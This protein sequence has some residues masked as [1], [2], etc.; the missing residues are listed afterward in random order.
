MQ[1][2]SVQIV[3][4]F[5]DIRSRNPRVYAANNNT[6]LRQYGKNQ[7]I[8]PNIPEC[9]GSVF[10]YFT[11]LVSVLFGG[12]YGKA[13]ICKLVCF[14]VFTRGRHYGAERAIR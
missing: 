7:H 8:T 11:D 1:R 5:G 14:I 4:N 2:R 6:F 9:P 12:R 13:A 10:T 3:Y